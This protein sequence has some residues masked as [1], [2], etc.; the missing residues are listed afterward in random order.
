MREG[1]MNL[2]LLYTRFSQRK[3]FQF[4]STSFYFLKVR[5]SFLFQEGG[6]HQDRT[7]IPFLLFQ[8]LM[9]I[10]VPRSNFVFSGDY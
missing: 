7:E 6:H 2:F 9:M 5:V 1:M 8:Y 3:G 10:E 4:E